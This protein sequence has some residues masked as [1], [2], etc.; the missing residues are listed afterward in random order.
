MKEMKFKIKSK[1][2]HFSSEMNEETVT[3]MENALKVYAEK[4]KDHE[5]VMMEK[6]K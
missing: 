1:R 6:V 3:G 5:I 4:C 2:Y